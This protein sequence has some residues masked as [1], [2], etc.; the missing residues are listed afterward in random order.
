MQYVLGLLGFLGF[1]VFAGWLV[2]PHNIIIRL[3]ELMHCK[4]SLELDGLLDSVTI[5]V[6]SNIA[7]T[8]AIAAVNLEA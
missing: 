2:G 1:W 5:Y 7:M 3:L 4:S 8:F 6:I